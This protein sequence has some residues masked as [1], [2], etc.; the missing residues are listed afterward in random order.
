M[1]TYAP[2]VAYPIGVVD[3]AFAPLT[4]IDA[5]VRA[6]ELGFEYIDISQVEGAPD[7]FS[8]DGQL[9]LP[10]HDHCVLRPRRIV[11]CW[12]IV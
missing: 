5:A 1:G 11:V 12:W 7:V 3:L 8:W 6:R 4:P 10:I 2:I 9:A